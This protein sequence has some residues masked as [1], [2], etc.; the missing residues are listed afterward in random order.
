MLKKLHKKLD[1]I[2]AI[3]AGADS[4]DAQDH[5]EREPF[6]E[7]LCCQQDLGAISNIVEELQ[8]ML[9]E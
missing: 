2:Q 9:G 8:Q 4:P 1:E 7:L 6:E 3:C 5:A